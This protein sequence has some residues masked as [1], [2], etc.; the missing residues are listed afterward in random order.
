MQK[1][2]GPFAQR[3]LG[4]V[5]R[6]HQ[7]VEREYGR[8]KWPAVLAETR[9]LLETGETRLDAIVRQ[10]THWEYGNELD[11]SIEIVIN[12]RQVYI[13][14]LSALAGFYGLVSGE[15]I[16]SCRDDTQV[17]L[18][19]CAGWGRSLFLSW[20]G[21]AP[22]NARYGCLEFTEAGRKS[23]DLIG[24]TAPE[25]QLNAAKFD[26]HNPD[27]SEW[28]SPSGHVVVTTTYGIEQAPEIGFGLFERILEI[29]PAVDVIHF[30]PIGWQ[31]RE[32]A[33]CPDYV[34]SSSEYAALNDTN[35]NLWSVLT[36]LQEEGRITI[37]RVLPDIYG[38]NPR[39]A[40]TLIHWRKRNC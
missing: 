18:D 11:G 16:R 23:A 22:K 13:P 15:I 38:L 27:L 3:A 10:L 33:G 5:R 40:A 36:R 29:A 26:L 8:E 17:L 4:M 20:S 1:D 32:S 19:L 24:S 34:G 7:W 9:R 12:G 30:E 28:R 31:C 39:N 21:G 35:V 37:V 25:M 6:D 14:T 2:T